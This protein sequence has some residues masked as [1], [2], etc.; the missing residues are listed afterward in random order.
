MEINEMDPK[1]VVK[2]TNH[3]YFEEL[4]VLHL[5]VAACKSPAVSMMQSLEKRRQEC[6]MAEDHMLRSLGLGP[7]DPAQIE[8]PLD[9]A[10]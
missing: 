3:R 2:L 9:G 6:E 8:I 10:A 7:A 4:K 5:V 1:E